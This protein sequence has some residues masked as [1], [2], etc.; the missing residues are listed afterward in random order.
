M[1]L[2]RQYIGSFHPEPSPIEDWNKD[3]YIDY[4]PALEGVVVDDSYADT[5]SESKRTCTVQ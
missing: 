2:G 4:E 5:S 1:N 3:V